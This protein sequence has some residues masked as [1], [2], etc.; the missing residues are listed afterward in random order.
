VHSGDIAERLP[1]GQFRIVDRKKELIIT[2]LARTSRRP[3]RVVAA[4]PIIARRSRWA[5]AATGIASC[6]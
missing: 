3:T 4:S 1:D 5:T 2:P 6:G